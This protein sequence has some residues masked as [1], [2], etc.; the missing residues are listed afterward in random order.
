MAAPK[1]KFQFVLTLFGRLVRYSLSFFNA[2]NPRGFDSLRNPPATK[3]RNAFS[4][5]VVKLS[6]SVAGDKVHLGAIFSHPAS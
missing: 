5:T 6:E 3:E 2:V 4:G 1:A